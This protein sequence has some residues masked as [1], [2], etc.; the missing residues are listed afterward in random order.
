MVNNR[1]RGHSFE[2]EVIHDLKEVYP[3]A[4][5]SRQES[6]SLDAQKVDIC[7]TP[8][9]NFQCKVHTQRVDYSGILDS[10]PKTGINV[11][12]HKYAVR[13]KSNFITKGKYAILK[14][15]DFLNLLNERKKD[16]T[17]SAEA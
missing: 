3:R 9:F 11:V 12:L 5:S 15:E 2:L 6:R 16:N 1:R 14:Y 4:V 8:P 17:V 7:Y 13:T 10:M